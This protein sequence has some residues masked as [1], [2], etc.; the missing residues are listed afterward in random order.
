MQVLNVVTTAEN[1]FFR[2]QVASLERLGVTETTVSIPGARP[3]WD[4]IGT[5]ERTPLEYLRAYPSV[6]RHAL[7]DYD[8]LH[9]NFGLTAP[10]ALAQ[11]RLPVVLTLWGTDLLG[12]YGRVS[13]WCA[14]RCDAVVVMSEAM[15]DELDTPC[16]VIPHGVDLDR[17]APRPQ[18]GARADVGWRPD[19]KHVLFPYPPARTVKNYPRAERIVEG[20]R[21][22]L[23]GSIE[24]HAISGV[25]HDR[26]PDYMNAADA[27]L[28]TSDREGSPNVVKEAMACNLPVVST[29][30]GDVKERLADVAPSAVGETD[31]ELIDELATILDV[32]RRSD[33]RVEVASVGLD[34]MARRLHKVYESVTSPTRE[35]GTTPLELGSE[36]PSTIGPQR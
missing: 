35:S 25:P 30:V 22:R 34:R 18:E 13:R 27:L 29:D 5:G 1:T 32:G 19:A 9:A 36:S 11:P 12:R 4:A 8:L 14:R 24:L 26:V 23:D 16:H 33:G 21:D 20:A 6:L 28:L 3:G 10:L 31:T 15:A 7:G 2:D 17:F